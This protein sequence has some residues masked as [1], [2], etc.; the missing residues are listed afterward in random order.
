VIATVLC[1]NNSD[2]LLPQGALL[3]HRDADHETAHRVIRL[4]Q[5]LLEEM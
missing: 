1:P 5:Q 3:L 2:S 4:F